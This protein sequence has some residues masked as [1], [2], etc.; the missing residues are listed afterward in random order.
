MNFDFFCTILYLVLFAIKTLHDTKISTIF[1]L[2][3]KKPLMQLYAQRTLCFHIIVIIY[4]VFTYASLFFLM[5]FTI[6]EISLTSCIN[7]VISLNWVIL[8]MLFCEKS[9]NPSPEGIILTFIRKYLS[10]TIIL[11]N[12]PVSLS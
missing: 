1:Q 9:T 8:I 5:S 12:S 6:S 11:M 7:S 4:I 2:N 10:F 3:H